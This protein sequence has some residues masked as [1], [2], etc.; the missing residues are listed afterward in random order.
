MIVSRCIAKILRSGPFANSLPCAAFAVARSGG[1]GPPP[2]Q[3]RQAH[4]GT[5]EI[6]TFAARFCPISC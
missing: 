4:G 5:P 3:G 1:N 2:Y 6:A